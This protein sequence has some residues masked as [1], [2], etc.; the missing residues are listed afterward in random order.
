MKTF[1]LYQVFLP[2]IVSKYLC[3]GHCSAATITSTATM[4]VVVRKQVWMI[5]T[6]VG[7]RAPTLCTACEVRLYAK[8]LFPHDAIITCSYLHAK[9]DICIHKDLLDCAFVLVDE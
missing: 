7:P 9:T 4:L 8:S 6:P 2:V 3:P 5:N 1:I